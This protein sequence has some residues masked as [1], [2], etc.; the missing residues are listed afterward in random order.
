MKKSNL[1]NWLVV[2]LSLAFLMLYLFIAIED[3]FRLGIF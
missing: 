3:V 1:K 2:A